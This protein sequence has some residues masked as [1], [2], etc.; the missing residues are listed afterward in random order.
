MSHGG[1]RRVCLEEYKGDGAELPDAH[2]PADLQGQD[3]ECG[4]G[5]DGRPGQLHQGLALM[6]QLHLSQTYCL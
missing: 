3:H 1:S 4:N 5:L 6:T 2:L